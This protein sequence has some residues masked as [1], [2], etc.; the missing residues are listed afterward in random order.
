MVIVVIAPSAP[1]QG[2]ALNMP[3]LQENVR[4]LGLC[5]IKIINKGI[6]SLTDRL[7]LKYLSV[8]NDHWRFISPLID[9]WFSL[10]QHVDPVQKV[11]NY[12]SSNLI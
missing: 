1:V 12:F 2:R 4:L 11:H 6:L 3:Q 7:R 9:E 5:V 10:P 8:K